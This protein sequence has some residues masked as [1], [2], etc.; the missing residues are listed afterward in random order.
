M[1]RYQP[2]RKKTSFLLPILALVLA[3]VISFSAL[4][5]LFGFRAVLNTT[6]YPFQ[7]TAAAVWKTTASVPAFVFNLAGLAGKNAE[8]KE[9]ISLMETKVSLYDEVVRENER[10][11]QALGFS[12]LSR[13]GFR[14]LPSAVTARSGSIFEI[15]RGSASGVRENL[16]AVTKDGL[17]GRVI[18]TTPFSA[19]I[20]VI[21]DV[22][23][24]VAAVDQQTRASGV[25]VGFSPA[26]LLMKFVS[27]GSGIKEG[28]Q[29]VTSSA[30]SFFPAGIPI[31]RISRAAKNPADLF[32]AIEVK[33]AARL[34]SLEEIYVLLK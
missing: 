19:K 27:E 26:K 31:G 17:V 7:F 33:P 23:S 4:Q 12:G 5:D 14:V 9:K 28:D 6:I 8:L 20:L 13:Y 1:S 25:I 3:L 22:L 10:L 2:F 21:T 29:V 34:S 11:R 32:Y 30:S 15:N 24:S 18:E 16:P